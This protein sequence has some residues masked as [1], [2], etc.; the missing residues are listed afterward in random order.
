MLCAVLRLYTVGTCV[1]RQ[2]KSFS[3]SYFRYIEA[4][5]LQTRPGAGISDVVE[6]KDELP[7]HEP[8]SASPSAPHGPSPQS[9]CLAPLP[10]TAEA[11]LGR[12]LGEPSCAGSS[13]S[14]T[15]QA[16]K[17]SQTTLSSVRSPVRPKG[18]PK[19]PG[20]IVAYGCIRLPKYLILR[21]LELGE[22]LPFSRV[23]DIRLRGAARLQVRLVLGGV[24]P[25]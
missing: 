4:S 1:L 11:S 2:C 17:R 24:K 14:S 18:L 12:D 10:Q 15:H 20:R 16:R 22:G 19:C 23:V 13:R 7:T 3:V 21:P 8:R 25:V 9:S 5:S 6:V